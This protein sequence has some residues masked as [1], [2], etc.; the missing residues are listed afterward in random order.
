MNVSEYLE[1]FIVNS[2]TKYHC[3]LIYR[4]KVIR[5]RTMVTKFPAQLTVYIHFKTVQFLALFL[6]VEF[7][8]FLDCENNIRSRRLIVTHIAFILSGFKMTPK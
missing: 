2:S 7:Y 8:I 5:K 4:T 6:K 1:T 3:F